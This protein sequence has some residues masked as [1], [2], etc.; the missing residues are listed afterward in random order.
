MKV[1]KAVNYF[2]DYHKANSKK[3]TTRNQSFILNRFQNQFSD[4]ELDSITSN[5]ILSFLNQFTQGTKQTTKRIRYANLKTFF[6]FV[7]SAFNFKFHNLCDT[8]VLKKI[9]REP[10]SPPWSII[11]K[12]EN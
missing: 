10:K 6:N 4:R 9:F 8:P 11:E 7:I 2:L 1:T 5:E 12:Q 3:N